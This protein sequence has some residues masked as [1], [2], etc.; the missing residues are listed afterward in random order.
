[1]KHGHLRNKLFAANDGKV[2]NENIP[3]LN[4]LGAN[5]V[6]EINK[7]NEILDTFGSSDKAR[8]K[9]KR[10]S[11]LTRDSTATA[12]VAGAGEQGGSF[13]ASSSIAT[14]VS[15]SLAKL[16]RH[17][18]LYC[19][20]RQALSVAVHSSVLTHTCG[21]MQYAPYNLVPASH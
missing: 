12:T 15:D 1:M 19:R 11:L 2:L 6:E 7:A 14:V 17:S 5:W 16:V 8:A 3:A 4:S 10:P 21:S 20:K 18:L 9:E 13:S